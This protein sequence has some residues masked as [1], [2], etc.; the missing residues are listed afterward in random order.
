MFD[1]ADKDGNGFLDRSEF[2]DILTACGAAVR[3]G[4]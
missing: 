3:S 4:S 2:I 1:A